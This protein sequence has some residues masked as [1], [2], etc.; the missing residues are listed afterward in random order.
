MSSFFKELKDKKIDMTNFINKAIAKN[1]LKIK[2]KKFKS[3]WYEIDN[4]KD[5]NVAKKEL[6]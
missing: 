2:A 6:K 5:F 3:Y 1:I 4:E